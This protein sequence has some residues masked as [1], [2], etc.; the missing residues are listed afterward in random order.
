[1]LTR[2]TIQTNKRDDIIEITNQ[3]R[4]YIKS[5]KINDGVIVVYCP[6]TTAAITINENADPDVVHDMNFRLDEMV[7]LQHQRDL[8]GEGNSAAHVKASMFGASET[9]IVYNGELL[10]GIWQGIYFCEFDGPRT[11]NYFIKT[12]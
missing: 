4:D 2:M 7:P 1:M 12:M 9:I 8:H 5:Q 11:R 6:H 10:L 3:V